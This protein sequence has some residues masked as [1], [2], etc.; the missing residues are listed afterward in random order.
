MLITR[1]AHRFS[2]GGTTVNLQP[3]PGSIASFDLSLATP[4]EI[5]YFFTSLRYLAGPSRG[6]H[7]DHLAG[8][9]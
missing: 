4:A 3:K 2:S 8:G 1:F 7:C 6:A 9:P 5:Y